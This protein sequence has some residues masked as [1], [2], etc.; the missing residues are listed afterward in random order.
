M[1]RSE[2]PPSSIGEAALGFVEMTLKSTKSVGVLL[3]VAG[4]LAGAGLAYWLGSARQPPERVAQQEIVRAARVVAVPMIEVRPV[5]KGYGVA[6]PGTA[7]QAVARVAGTIVYRHPELE[8]GSILAAGTRLLAIDPTDYE[9]AIAETKAQIAALEAEGDQLSA[10]QTNL[11]SLLRIER[12]RLALAE[13]E[14]ERTRSLVE[15]GATPAARLDEQESLTL[16]ARKAVQELDNQVALLPSRRQRLE[17]E[18]AQAAS[19]LERARR[20]LTYST[21]SA[22]L[23]MRVSEVNV[24]Q[25]QFVATGQQLLT[26]DGIATAEVSAQIQF[27]AFRR[28]I[29]SLPFAGDA[30]LPSNKIDLGAIDARVRLVAGGGAEW[31]GQIARIEGGLDPRIRTAQVVVRVD[32]PYRRAEPPDRPALVKNMHVEVELTGR[33]LPAMAVV[34]AAAVHEDHVYVLDDDNRLILRPVRIAFRQNG[35]ALVREGLSGGE[36]VVIDDLVP[37]TAGMAIAPRAA[38]DVEEWLASAAGGA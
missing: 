27:E 17:A 21:V 5:A 4:L 31:P 36:R 11:E 32:E 20:D 38:P 3:L 33:P 29:S 9:A 24:E 16:N 2:H 26:A 8:D 7:W 34:P 18:I 6:R 22:P 10:D 37:A 14:L 30:V 28:I 25:D 12:D 19:R 15:R 23:D 1:H 13:R 35:L